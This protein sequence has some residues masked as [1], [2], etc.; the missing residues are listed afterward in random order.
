MVFNPKRLEKVTLF[1]VDTNYFLAKYD[2][3]FACHHDLDQN[4]ASAIP[5]I[6]HNFAD[7]ENAK[8]Y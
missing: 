3:S 7:T 1:A 4:E 5:V 6:R 2:N 8:R